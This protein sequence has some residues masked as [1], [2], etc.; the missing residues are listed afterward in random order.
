MI[1]IFLITGFLEAMSYILLL[2]VAMPLK[3]ILGIS[4]PVTYIGW[5]HGALFIAYLGIL[6][7]L[8]IKNKWK[9]TYGILGFVAAMLPFGPFIF[10]KYLKKE[11]QLIV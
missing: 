4:S 6:G 11:E 2:G 1:K 8:I 3:Y 10:E 5:A 7:L 9:W